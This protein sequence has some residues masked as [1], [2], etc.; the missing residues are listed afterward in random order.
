MERGRAAVCCGHTAKPGLSSYTWQ[1]AECLAAGRRKLN[2]GMRL[3]GTGI[4]LREGRMICRG[5][6]AIRWAG[7]GTQR[8]EPGAGWL[9]ALPEGTQAEPKGWGR[10]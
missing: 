7:L 1:R 8:A 2:P 5:F 6:Y 10:T 4:T 9:Q 3:E